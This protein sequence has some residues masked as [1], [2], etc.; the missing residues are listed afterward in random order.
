MDQR[1]N[2][3][4]LFKNDKKEEAKHPDY[5]GEIN[6]EGES[7]WLS[8]WLKDGQKGKFM[9]IAATPKKKQQGKKDE[10]IPL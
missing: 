6:I 7:F 5:K 3:G 10:D 9:S 2:S 8:A 4:I 1:N